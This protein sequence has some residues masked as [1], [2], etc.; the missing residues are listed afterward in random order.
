[1]TSSLGQAQIHLII[2]KETQGS[3]PSNLVNSK[4]RK[5]LAQELRSSHL[6]K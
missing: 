5:L 1:M 2:L 4:T 3:K 6:I